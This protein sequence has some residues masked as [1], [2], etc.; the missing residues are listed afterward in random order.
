MQQ[1]TPPITSLADFEVFSHEHELDGMSHLSLSVLNHF[2]FER[3]AGAC[4]PRLVVLHCC[5]S[6]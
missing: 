3:E 5:R 1:L 4:M 2:S 6:C